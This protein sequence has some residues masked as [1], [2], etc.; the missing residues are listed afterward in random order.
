MLL[1]FTIN[2]WVDEWMD[3]HS[4][5]TP[6]DPVIAKV[7][8]D[9]NGGLRNHC[10]SSFLHPCTRGLTPEE[11]DVVAC[12]LDVKSHPLRHS[13]QIREASLGP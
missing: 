4:S 7:L 10:I 9:A 11:R 2:G 8:P 5:L 6:C 3:G 13:Y 12:R 1:L